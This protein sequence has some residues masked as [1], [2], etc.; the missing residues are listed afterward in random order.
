MRQIVLDT[1]T[2]GLEPELGH[3]IIEIGCVELINRRL[4]GRTYH[5][6]LCPD[7]EI[8]EAALDVHG[9]ND[10]FLA[11]KP[12]FADVFP[13]FL[14][15]VDGA[16]VLIHNAPFDTAFLDY[17]LSLLE[18]DGLGNIVDHCRI[19]DTLAFARRKHPGLKN[20]L[21]ALCKRYEV[22]NSRRELHGALLDAQLLAE[23]YLSMTG[24][25]AALL[26]DGDEDEAGLTLN[27]RRS[28]IDRTGLRLRIRRASVEELA[29]HERCLDQIEESAG[30]QPVWR[31]LVTATGAA[32][33]E[34]IALTT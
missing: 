25:Q 15:F 18:Q 1:E 2:T 29:A 8:D 11:D 23:V 3:R 9:L 13:D 34:E 17:E 22:D 5:Q 30:V 21:D 16:E 19:L 32:P 14:A 6:Y 28:R 27:E 33:S 20:S 24:G 10:E 7:R 4:T 26:F 31:R 12:R